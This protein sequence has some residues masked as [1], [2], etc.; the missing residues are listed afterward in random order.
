[1]E[2]CE[3]CQEEHEGLVPVINSL[4]PSSEVELFCVNCAEVV[5]FETFDVLFLW[6]P[7]SFK[8]LVQGRTVGTLVA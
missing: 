3:C 8:S 6:S 1:M 2:R 5:H 7:V 4:G